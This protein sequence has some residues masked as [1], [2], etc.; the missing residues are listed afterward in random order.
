MSCDF[1]ARAV[2]GVQKLSPYVPGKPVDELARELNLDPA[3]IVKLAS[4]ENPLGPS[5]K[6]LEAIRAELAELTRYPDGNGFELKQKLAA[7]CG[8]SVAQVTLGNG[9]NDILDLVAR[10]WLAPGLNAVFSQYAFAVYPIATQ[11]VG[12]QGKAVPAKAHGHD[13]EAMLAAIDGNTRVV[14]IAN[15]NNP[16]G[17]WFGPDALESFLARVPQD[18]LVVL[19]EAYIEYAEGDELPDGL[20]YLVRYPNLIVSRTFSKAYGLASLR[21]GYALSSPQVA[22][23]LNR[24]RQ[25]FN[26]N[27]L[28]LSAACAALDDADYLAES[29][30]VNDAGMAQL[31]AGFAE[32]GLN[33]IP[34]KGNFIAVDFARD[35]APIN[36]ALL[37]EGVIVRPVGGYGMPTFLRVSIGTR[38]EN[39]RFLDVLGQVLARG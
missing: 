25:P 35:A 23:V 21:V 5:P 7:R 28:A 18:V 38:A 10:A 12:A 22:D 36:R 39:A 14:F 15:P 34:S 20:D 27:S 30:R 19:D 24:V 32:L 37:Q 9:S 16:T 3:G 4:N 8:V 6:A 29:R 13:L 33:W 2:P 17:T 11:A 26:V 1:L 31:E